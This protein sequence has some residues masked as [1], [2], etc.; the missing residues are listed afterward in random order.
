M[1]CNGKGPP[2][3]TQAPS[4]AQ[5][6]YVSRKEAK[7]DI[8]VIENRG[9][10]LPSADKSFDLVYAR[11]MLHHAD[12]LRALCKE[13]S[14]V[15]KPRGLFIATREHVIANEIFCRHSLTA[16][17][18]TAAQPH[19]DHSNSESRGVG[20]QSFPDTRQTFKIRLRKK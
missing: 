13:V 9:E 17:L 12:D 16:T 6:R 19:K 2:N 14:R 18:Y 10:R 8:T 3:R 11:Q 7:L 1:E 4:W 5:E 15:L 20:H